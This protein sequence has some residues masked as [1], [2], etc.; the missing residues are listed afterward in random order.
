MT[1]GKWIIEG[2][3]N[4]LLVSFVML[5]SSTIRGGY[6]AFLLSGVQ[7]RLEIA[8]FEAELREIFRE[9]VGVVGGGLRLHGDG[10]ELA[11]GIRHGGGFAADL[12]DVRELDEVEFVEALGVVGSEKGGEVDGVVTRRG[13]RYCG[14]TRRGRRVYVGAGDFLLH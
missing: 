6:G 9:A 8:E 1:N 12:D 10:E 3:V 4:K 11:R 13:R 5:A 7:S 14:G 2:P